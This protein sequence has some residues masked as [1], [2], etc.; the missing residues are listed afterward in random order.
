MKKFSLF[1]AAGFFLLLTIYSVNSKL[2]VKPV[3]VGAERTL[4]Y[5]P[6]LQGKKVAIVANHTSL[7]RNTHLVDTLIS[8]GIKIEKIFSPEHGFR[9]DVDAGEYFI[10]YIDSITGLQVIS[11]YGK[12]FKPKTKD[13]E[14]LEIM[15]FDIQDVGV[16]FY[17][18]ISTLHYIMEACAENNIELIVLDRPNPNGF[19]IDG[20]VMQNDQMSFVGL[21]P[22]P[23]VYGMTIGELAMMINGEKW[24][25]NN[26]SC[27]LKV[28]SCENY[29]HNTYYNLPVNPSPNL[30]NM[31]AIYLYPSLGLFEGT[32]VS[33]GRGTE[34][35]FRVIGF[36]EYHDTTFMFTPRSINGISKYPMYKDSICYG[37]NLQ[38]L[39]TKELRDK[40]QIDLSW[41]IMMYND[42]QDYSFFND[43]FEML[44]GNNKLRNQIIKGLSEEE[45]RKS[46]E[47]DLDTFKQKRQR[48][49][50]YPDFKN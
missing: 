26:L 7:I 8:A 35:P 50:L 18:Y 22:I 40:E 44:V 48:Y 41:I 9:G 34:F 1:L 49:L 24:L 38:N 25:K 36:P 23:V 37:I 46:W 2:N 47:P 19:Y 12:N 29:T 43:Y 11:L 15:V 27:I 16:R 17:T 28:I 45:I 6:L 13:V 33:V 14:G 39:N 3:K 10:D 32:I 31:E 42:Y 21:H 5:L 20:P 30:Q 4:Q